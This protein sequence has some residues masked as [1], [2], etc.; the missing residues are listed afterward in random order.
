MAR[1]PKP[2]P[3]RKVKGTDRRPVRPAPLDGPALA[4]S[5]AYVAAD[6]N[7]PTTRWLL[8]G[9]AALG[10][11]EHLAPPPGHAFA[12]RITSSIEAYQRAYDEYPGW[13]TGPR[14]A[15][16]WRAFAKTMRGEP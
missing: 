6:P 2:K 8:A 3:P 4:A 1:L 13:P 11:D 12:S 15:R 7:A 9:I 14:V 5:Q 16:A 10:S